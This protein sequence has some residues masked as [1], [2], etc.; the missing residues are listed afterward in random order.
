M[1]AV[2]AR[3][4]LDLNF[5]FLPEHVLEAEL[6]REY[7]GPREGRSRWRP[8][9]FRRESENEQPYK[10]LKQAVFAAEGALQDPAASATDRAEV[11]WEL[12]KAVSSFPAVRSSATVQGAPLIHRNFDESP[13]RDRLVRRHEN[14]LTLKVFALTAKRLVRDLE[15]GIGVAQ[16]SHAEAFDRLAGVPSRKAVDS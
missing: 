3:I 16:A 12:M 1:S 4:G 7:Q 6:E 13:E 8:F 11:A 9:L 5:F 14:P 10:R 2:A 15:Q